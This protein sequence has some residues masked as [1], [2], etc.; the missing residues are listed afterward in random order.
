MFLRGGMSRLDKVKERAGKVFD[1]TIG[2]RLVNASLADQ[3]RFLRRMLVMPGSSIEL[4][5]KGFLEDLPKEI[6]EK[7]N[8]GMSVEEIKTYYWGC[9]P[10]VKL[11]HQ[12]PGFNEATLDELIRQGTEQAVEAGQEIGLLNESEG[13]SQ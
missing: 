6:R 11:W 4:V 10:F 2:R 8:N 9:E 13:G 5:G 3:V 7:Y 12:I 1:K